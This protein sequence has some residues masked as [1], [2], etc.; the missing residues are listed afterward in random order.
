MSNKMWGG[1]FS[2][3]PD[4]VME[5]INA[6]IDFDRRLFAQD[7]AGSRAHADMLAKQGIISSEDAEAINHGL[8]TILSEIEAGTFEFSRALEDIHMNVE[9][10]L[11]DLIGPAAGRLHTARSRN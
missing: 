6:S 2:R 5:A 1:R 8:N 3:G 9:A 10:R 7:I 4:A 11:A